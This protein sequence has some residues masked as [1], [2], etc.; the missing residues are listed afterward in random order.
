MI[1]M[2][3]III[4]TVISRSL[5]YQQRILNTSLNV[6]FNISSCELFG[7]FVVSD[8]FINNTELTKNHQCQKQASL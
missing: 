5:S 7:R 8:E 2:D 1:K 6:K 3:S 4:D